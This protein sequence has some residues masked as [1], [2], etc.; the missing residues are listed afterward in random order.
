MTLPDV[1]HM[2]THECTCANTQARTC[3][4]RQV[5]TR[6]QGAHL[7]TH[8]TCTHVYLCRFTHMALHMHVH[9]DTHTHTE[10]W[11]SLQPHS[12]PFPT[13]LPEL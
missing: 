3:A 12:Q 5:H 6:M 13:K 11:R 7:Y 2:P 8:S 9:A 10:A 1:V 4:H